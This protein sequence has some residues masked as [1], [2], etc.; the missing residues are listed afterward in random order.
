MLLKLRYC[1]EE[2]CVPVI[3][4]ANAADRCVSLASSTLLHKSICGEH[5]SSECQACQ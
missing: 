1:M 3:H 4:P 2:P 5:I